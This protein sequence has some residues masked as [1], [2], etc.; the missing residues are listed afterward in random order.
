MILVFAPKGLCIPAQGCPAKGWAT[1]GEATKIPSTPKGLRKTPLT[2]ALAVTL[3]ATPLGLHDLAVLG[4]VALPHPQAG[5]PTV[6]RN[7]R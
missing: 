6:A 4:M 2:P 5:H 7:Q 1:L 3:Y